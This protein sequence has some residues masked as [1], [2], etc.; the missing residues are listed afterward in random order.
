MER[1]HLGYLKHVLQI[2][3]SSCTPALYADCGRFPIIIKQ[4]CQIIQYWHRLLNLPENHILSYAYRSQLK[5][6]RLGY[7]NWCKH[8]KDILLAIDMKQVWE[9]QSIDQSILFMIKEKLY[10]DFM[11]TTLENIKN[12]DLHPKLRTYKLFKQEYKLEN[13][14][15][16]L[17][18]LQYIKALI[19][20]RISSHNLRIET[21]RYERVRLPNGEIIKLEANKRICKICDSNNVEDEIHFLL[22]CQRLLSER[23]NMLN[24]IGQ[25]IEDF[26]TSD[27][28]TKFQKIMSSN[29]TKVIKPLVS[30]REWK[31]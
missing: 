30:K 24:E 19:R 14:L 21:G 2:K 26:Y 22:E 25:H 23:S 29:D 12:P 20:F 15:T 13:Y 8:V 28:K 1:L 6:H 31:F 10:H 9:Q 5:L 3:R 11:N 7:D 18:D 16:Q 17:K 4:K 27:N